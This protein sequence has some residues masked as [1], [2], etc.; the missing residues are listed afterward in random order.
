MAVAMR[1][2]IGKLVNTWAARGYDL[3]LG[4][5]ISLGYATLG[6]IGFEGRFHYGA[7]GSVL[8]LASR[9]CDQAQAGQI[10]ITPRV[11]AEAGEL[12]QVEDLG[13]L[14]L[15]GFLKPVRA[16]SVVSLNDPK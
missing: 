14:A 10:L 16:L 8:N 7:I 3:G 12:A 11:Q 9:L 15:K 4:I 6:Q 13:E 5:G 1:D 2:E